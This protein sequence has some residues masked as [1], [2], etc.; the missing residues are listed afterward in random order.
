[1]CNNY[2]NNNILI[3]DL[4]GDFSNLIKLN[5]GVNIDITFINNKNCLY[6]IDLKIYSLAFVIVENISDVSAFFYLY[7]KINK[8]YLG[9]NST[10][11]KEEI[12]NFDNN[13]LFF[14]LNNKN[15]KIIN[16]IYNYMIE[17]NI[18]NLDFNIN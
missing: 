15:E 18:N 13:I 3:Y 12:K 4:I 9:T 2:S 16:L 11:I 5:C 8:T 10:Y 6:K 1:M 17:F 14:D 7:S